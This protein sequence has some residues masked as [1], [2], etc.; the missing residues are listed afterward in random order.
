MILFFLLFVALTTGQTPTNQECKV[1]GNY[2]DL[3]YFQ[4]GGVI[5]VRAEK[6]IT[7][8]IKVE[9]LTMASQPVMRPFQVEVGSCDCPEEKSFGCASL[10][11]EVGA[12]TGWGFAVPAS[13][14]A[15]G[16]TVQFLLQ[17][18]F[19]KTFRLLNRVPFIAE[20][21]SFLPLLQIGQVGGLQQKFVEGLFLEPRA[22]WSFGVCQRADGFHLCFIVKRAGGSGTA[23][24]VYYVFSDNNPT[25]LDLT[26]DIVTFVV[27]RNEKNRDAPRG[28]VQ[29]TILRPQTDKPLT[30]SSQI[31][32]EVPEL[33]DSPFVK[34]G[35]Q[36]EVGILS[37]FD[38]FWAAN[39]TAFSHSELIA[40][41]WANYF[42]M[43]VFAGNGIRCKNTDVV[44]T[45]PT[46]AATT[47]GEITKGAEPTVP[48]STPIPDS[49]SKSTLTS[50]STSDS[51]LDDKS[52]P[53]QLRNNVAG[54]TVVANLN[55]NFASGP[56]DWIS[57]LLFVGAGLLI[58]I[59][60]VLV[61][62]MLNRRQS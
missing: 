40:R 14:I 4:F 60:A 13:T 47:K 21:A 35:Y 32:P 3:L 52:L 17:E 18:Q 41:G 16:G 29:A 20:T 48:V 38:S 44:R 23:A 27:S 58:V 61:L 19:S 54:T 22:T 7:P 15:F 42:C 49:I 8:I 55:P 36:T 30:F 50:M 10:G 46:D 43:D 34:I 59:G 24:K 37:R 56:V 51:T 25:P 12:A 26:Q 5:H 11:G 62:M 6:Q 28:V 53:T 2:S 33:T 31:E 45:R 57:V 1:G 9:A 39:S